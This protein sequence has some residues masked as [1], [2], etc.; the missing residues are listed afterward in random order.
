MHTHRTASSLTLALLTATFLTRPES[1]RA[2][3]GDTL[4]GEFQVD[5]FIT[6]SQRLP[7]VAM[8]ADEGSASD[9][10]SIF[11]DNSH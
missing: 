1:T 11:L 3:P 8:D 9:A 6:S 2:A 10:V 5:T 7:A 4:G